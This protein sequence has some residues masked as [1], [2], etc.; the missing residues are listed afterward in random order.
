M[1]FLITLTKE[2]IMVTLKKGIHSTSIYICYYSIDIFCA[3]MATELE[4]KF[5]IQKRIA[6]YMD[7]IF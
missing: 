3:T 6:C 5:R 2:P 4:D 7:Y 1:P